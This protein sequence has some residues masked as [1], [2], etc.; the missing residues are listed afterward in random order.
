MMLETQ[1]RDFWR[2]INLLQ[3]NDLLQYV[4]VVGSWAE[5]LYSQSGLLEGF[6]ANL[7][8]L[9][10]DFLIKNMRRTVTPVSISSLAAEAGYTIDHDVIEGTT[11]IYTPD[12]MEIEFVIEQK[13][14][15]ENSVLKTNLGVKAQAL[16]HLSSLTNNLIT[17]QIF[18]FSILVP[19]PEAYVIHKIIINQKRGVKAEKDIQSIIGL[20][21]YLNKL[22][23]SEVRE[24]LTLKEKCK[25]DEFINQKIT[26]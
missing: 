16:R 15:G 25:V 2:F 4:V 12:L 14:R 9:D 13:G 21:P 3:T 11:K 19:A 17:V 5:Y 23:F 26:T 20:M 6:A 24:S 7:R 22:R 18:D 8:T 10:I 1:Y